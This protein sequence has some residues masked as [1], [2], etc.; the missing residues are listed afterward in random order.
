MDSFVNLECLVCFFL[1]GVLHIMSNTLARL[2]LRHWISGGFAETLL[3]AWRRWDLHLLWCSSHTLKVQ[4][5]ETTLYPTVRHSLLTSC[6][7][8]AFSILCLHALPFTAAGTSVLLRMLGGQRTALVTLASQVF[9]KPVSSLWPC[10]ESKQFA[11]EPPR[12]HL[13]LG[14]MLSRYA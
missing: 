14:W 11:L 13:C 12:R 7:H 1:G 8:R 9:A 2:L 4:L 3:S 10:N 5:W 6:P